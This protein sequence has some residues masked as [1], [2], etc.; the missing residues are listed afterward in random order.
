MDCYYHHG[1]ESTDNCA[2]CK[3]SICKECGLEISG[4]IYCKDC[5]EKIVGMGLQTNEP[6]QEQNRQ[7]EPIQ[8][9]QEPQYTPE[10]IQTRQEPQYTP[11]P[12]Q[13]RQDPVENSYDNRPP[14]LEKQEPQF[15]ID[16]ITN[17]ESYYQSNKNNQK[18]Q[19]QKENTLSPNIPE[20]DDF[21]YPDHSYQP[22]PRSGSNALEEKYERY[23]DELYDEPDIPLHEQLARDEEIYGSLTDEPYKPTLTKNQS[24]ESNYVENEPIYP[25]QNQNQYV[26]NDYIDKEPYKPTL[27]Q[28]QYIDDEPIYPSHEEEFVPEPRKTPRRPQKD[29]NEP[30]HKNIHYKE[31]KESMSIVDILL[32]IILIILII[33]VVL[34][35]IYL[36]VW[37]ST[38]PTFTDALFGLIN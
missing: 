3:K 21:I 5:L 7:A 32:T 9:R 2:I 27:N 10:P 15:D 29:N 12:I 19:K 20:E 17:N 22:E 18:I 34:Y 23:L 26:E 36:F 14:K 33:I 35:I 13:T 16:N 38:Y 24:L 37:S 4:K 30:I 8:T 6:S 31:E 25:S 28:N 11:E 1:R